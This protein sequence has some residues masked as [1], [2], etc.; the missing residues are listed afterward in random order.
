[1]KRLIALL[2]LTAAAVLAQPKVVELKYITRDDL[3]ALLAGFKLQHSSDQSGRV[4]V[5]NGDAAEMAAA[6]ALIRRM[7]VAQKNVELVFHIISAGGGEGASKVPSDL[8]PVVKQLRNSFAYA[9]YRTLESF[10]L[11]LRDG[12]IDARASGVLPPPAAD[13]YVLQVRR[14][15]ITPGEKG[16]VARLE[17]VVFEIRSLDTRVSAPEK[18][19]YNSAEIQASLDVREGQKVVVGKSNYAGGA[20]FLVVTARIVD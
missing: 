11:R 9:G 1:M 16:T 10:A 13:R 12:S 4:I 2:V 15:S 20:Y 17:R 3:G 7:D 5:L 14:I 6:E 18:P 19:V 8:E